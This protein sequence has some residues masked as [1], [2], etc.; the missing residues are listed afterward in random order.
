MAVLISNTFTELVF[1]FKPNIKHHLKS[2]NLIIFNNLYGTVMKIWVGI[3]LSLGSW[4]VM[5]LRQAIPLVSW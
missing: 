4:T 5:E 1:L 2:L 3:P